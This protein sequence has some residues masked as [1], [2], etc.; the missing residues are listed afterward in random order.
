MVDRPYPVKYTC[1]RCGNEF[2]VMQ[3]DPEPD[4]DISLCWDCIDLLLD[5]SASTGP[6]GV[7]SS[8]ERGVT[9]RSRTGRS[10]AETVKCMLCGHSFPKSEMR[11][12]RMSLDWICKDY[13][14]C[15]KRQK[16]KKNG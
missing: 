11:Q 9:C 12:M 7:V 2:T 13:E 3:G 8:A 14:A 6:P 4:E 15:L 5:K 10:M 1:R 16:E